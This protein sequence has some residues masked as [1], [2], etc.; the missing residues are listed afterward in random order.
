MA[1]SEYHPRTPHASGADD[2]LC[3][4]ARIAISISHILLGN[5]DRAITDGILNQQSN[6]GLQFISNLV[7]IKEKIPQI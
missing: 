4:T 5:D 7:L 2:T 1:E 6:Y 3:T